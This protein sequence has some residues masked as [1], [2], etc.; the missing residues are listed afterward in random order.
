MFFNQGD[1]FSKKADIN[2]G[3]AKIKELKKEPKKL[4]TATNFNSNLKACD[5]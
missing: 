2:K 1:L 4:H 3:L 5:L